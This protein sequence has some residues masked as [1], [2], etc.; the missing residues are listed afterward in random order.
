MQIFVQI[1]TLQGVFIA[2]K[3]H[4]AIIPSSD[5][6]VGILASH[7]AFMFKLSSGLVKLYENE[8]RI[9][10]KIF[11]F[12]GFAQVYKDKIDIVTDNAMNLEDLDIKH[13]QQKVKELENKLLNSEEKEYLNLI[14]KKLE[15]YRK[16]LEVARL[17]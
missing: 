10:N 11:I 12:N 7:A 6:E 16:M 5:G 17:K 2:K 13:A 4:M 3:T 8:T 1:A 14:Q 15:L 9:S